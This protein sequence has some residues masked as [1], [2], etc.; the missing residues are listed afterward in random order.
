MAFASMAAV[1]L[2]SGVVK[3]MELTFDVGCAGV[4]LTTDVGCGRA[5]SPFV[6]MFFLFDARVVTPPSGF[7]VAS[8][9]RCW[10]TDWSQFMN[11]GDF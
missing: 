3:V 1:T 4:E 11:S 6:F 8:L 10:L 7:C 2:T 5:V 9:S